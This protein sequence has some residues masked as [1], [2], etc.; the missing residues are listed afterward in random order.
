MRTTL[1]IDDDLLDRARREAAE[2]RL[3]VSEVVNR[4]LRRGFV[5]QPPSEGP[6]RT[7]TFGT[8][9]GA[10]PDRERLRAVL[11]DDELLWLRRKCGL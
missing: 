8:S 7:I 5:Q 2:R 6:L 10:P 9:G 3:T 4:T 11:D 1:A